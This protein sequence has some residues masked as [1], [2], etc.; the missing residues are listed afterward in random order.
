MT[1]ILEARPT[2]ELMERTA[3]AE[4]IR[5]VLLDL[6]DLYGRLP[7]ML[8]GC[9]QP[10]CPDHAP[11]TITIGR[12][13]TWLA[14]QG[15]RAT[16]PQVPVPP[17][18]R[19]DL[20]ERL[21][22]ALADVAPELGLYACDCGEPDCAAENRHRLPLH[23]LVLLAAHEW[24]ALA[25]VYSTPP[26]GLPVHLARSIR[27]NLRTVEQLTSLMMDLHPEAWDTVIA[28]YEEIEQTTWLRE[29][30]W[31]CR[32][33]TMMHL[34]ELN[35]IPQV[36]LAINVALAIAR[37]QP[38]YTDRQRHALVFA[39]NNVVQGIVFRGVADPAV[40]ESMYEPM[41]FVQQLFFLEEDARLRAA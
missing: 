8:C 29:A 32:V 7:E 28:R 11:A 5:A 18:T 2:R 6:A 25:S 30:E 34:P 26:E 4:E 19:A 39:I 15:E 33:A 14:E 16:E 22:T 31:L 12:L 40:T 13:L 23:G 41:E 27:E 3:A 37:S 1:A 38:G 10:E 36:S 21:R 17:A 24:M 20:E 9:Q 35:R